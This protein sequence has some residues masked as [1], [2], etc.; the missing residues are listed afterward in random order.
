MGM[1]GGAGEGLPAR[2]AHAVA[3]TNR[4]KRR[5]AARKFGTCIVFV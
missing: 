2:R 3:T 4:P 1:D 5:G